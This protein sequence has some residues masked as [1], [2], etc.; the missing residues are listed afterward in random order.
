MTE[1]PD[2]LLVLPRGCPHFIKGTPVPCL[3]AF[4]QYVAYF[5]KPARGISFSGDSPVP[6]KSFDLMKSGPPRLWSPSWHMHSLSLWQLPT[7]HWPARRPQ[8]FLSSSGSELTWAGRQSLN[9]SAYDCVQ[10][11]NSGRKERKPKCQTSLSLRSKPYFPIQLYHP[12]NWYI[13]PC[14]ILLFSN[15]FIAQRGKLWFIRTSNPTRCP[16]DQC[17]GSESHA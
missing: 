17:H 10:N 15:C 1:D 13:D 16:G 12:Q 4:L 9:V 7:P 11:F 5:V 3:V 2:F 8:A 6:L 14:L